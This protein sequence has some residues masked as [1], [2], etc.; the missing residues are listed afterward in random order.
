MPWTRVRCSGGGEETTKYKMTMV[1]GKGRGLRRRRRRMEPRKR[2]GVRALL[3]GPAPVRTEL[4]VEI[5]NKYESERQRGEA[6]EWMGS[7]MGVE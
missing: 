1:D 3:W 7:G 4:E 5:Q 2:G 6:G